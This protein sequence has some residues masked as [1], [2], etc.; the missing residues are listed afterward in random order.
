VEVDAQIVITLVLGGARSG[1]SAV[2]EALVGDDAVYVATAEVTDDDFA[3]RV[4]RHQARRPS[5]WTTVETVPHLPATDRSLPDRPALIDS[6]GTWVARCEGFAADAP[7]LVESLAGRTAVVVSE[8]VGLGVHP[9]TEVGRRWRDALGEV[10]QVVAAAADRVLL[11]VAG[12]V[13]EL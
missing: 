6:L 4:E 13:L 3:A 8:E 1:K 9:E 10:N 11:V 7:A 2:A 12:R 5:S